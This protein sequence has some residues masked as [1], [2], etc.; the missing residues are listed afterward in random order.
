MSVEEIPNK[1]SASSSPLLSPLLTPKL[2]LNENLIE[3]SG[4]LLKWTDYFKGYRK[5]WFVLSNGQFS[6]YRYF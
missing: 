4:P 6:Y 3:I 2:E 1:S 5:R